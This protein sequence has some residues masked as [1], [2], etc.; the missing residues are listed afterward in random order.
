MEKRELIRQLNGCK[1]PEKGAVLLYS[2]PSDDPDF[3]SPLP[4]AVVFGGYTA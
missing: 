4:Q 1:R 3:L 2:K